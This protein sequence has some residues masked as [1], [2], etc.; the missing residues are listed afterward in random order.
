ML[1]PSGPIA[2]SRTPCKKIRKAAALT[3]RW[4]LVSWSARD[5]DGAVTY[6]FGEDAEA[7]WFY[8]H[9]GWITVVL[10]AA[11]RPGPCQRLLRWENQE[12]AGSR[13][14]WFGLGQ[15]RARSGHTV[16][17]AVRAGWQG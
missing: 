3:G 11:D 8:T 1:L 17:G 10:A 2:L 16:T 7:A 5:E 13:P 6:P 4:R 14:S 9:A 12:A 15:L